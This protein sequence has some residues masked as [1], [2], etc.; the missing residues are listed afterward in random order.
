MPKN[1]V[2]FHILVSH[3]PSCLN[4]DDQNHQKSAVFGGV[5]RA[6]VSSQCL[7]RSMRTSAYYAEHLGNPSI[8]TH[9]VGM[10]RDKAHKALGDRFSKEII[11]QVLIAASGVKKLEE[12]ATGDA[13]APWFM[14]EFAYLCQRLPHLKEKGYDDKEITKALNNT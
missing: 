9:Q 5:R 12:G 10:L 6:R 2:N 14:E 13:V 3:P 4:R 1:F 11:D 7:K 8:R